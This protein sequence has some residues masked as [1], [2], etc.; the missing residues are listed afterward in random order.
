M[1]SFKDFVQS[2]IRDV[3]INFD[4]HGTTHNID[5][6]DFVIVVDSDTIA[7]RPFL[8][9]TGAVNMDP[10]GIYRETITFYVAA[11]EF[12]A[13][14]LEGEALRFDGKIHIVKSSVDSSGI[15]IVTIEAND[16]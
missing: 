1:S 8:R 15:Y 16:I 4:E 10:D 3:F 13:R 11:A 12:G 7:D 2:D 5:G 14:P 6:D 9:S